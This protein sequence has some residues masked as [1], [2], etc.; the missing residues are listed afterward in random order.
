MMAIK[1][2]ILVKKM[3]NKRYGWTN[4]R[5]NSFY[6]SN[7]PSVLL[8]VKTDMMKAFEKLFL[9]LDHSLKLLVNGD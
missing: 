3:I 6:K 4:P 8:C 2:N 5:G 7:I 9:G 1:T